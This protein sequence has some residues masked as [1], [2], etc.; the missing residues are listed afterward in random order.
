MYVCT[1]VAILHVCL[2]NC[3]YIGYTVFMGINKYACVLFTVLS[4]MFTTCL[5]YV[6]RVQWSINRC[7]GELCVKLLACDE[8]HLIIHTVQ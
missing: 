8:A 7:V 6:C 5:L 3:A 1:T 4:R 2:H